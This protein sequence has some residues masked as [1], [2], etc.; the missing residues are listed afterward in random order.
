M[1]GKYVGAFSEGLAKVYDNNELYFVNDKY[2]MVFKCDADIA[3]DFH[4]GLA[5]VYKHKRWGYIDNQGKL[6][7]DYLYN[8]AS[9]FRKGSSHCEN[10]SI[11]VL[12]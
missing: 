2:E 11:N 1:Q 6:V 9:D 10:R 7:I 3:G 8:Y 4:E 12:S 5:R